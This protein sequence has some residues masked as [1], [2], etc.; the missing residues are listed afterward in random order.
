MISSGI[1]PRELAPGVIWDE[2]AEKEFRE[3]AESLLSRKKTFVNIAYK[4]DVE[5]TAIREAVWAIEIRLHQIFIKK[6]IEEADRCF[7]PVEKRKL[8]ERWSGLYGKP[9]T[10]SL[11]RMV[12]NNEFRRTVLRKW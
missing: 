11:L 9:R 6:R 3:K 1:V 7:Q 5:Q 4:D 10:D 8:V 2:Y 12:R